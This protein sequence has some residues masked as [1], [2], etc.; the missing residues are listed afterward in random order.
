MAKRIVR[1]DLEFYQQS[2]EKWWHPDAKIYALHHLNPLCFEYFERHI[3]NWQGLKVLDV[4]CSG[5]FSCEFVAARQAQVYSIDRAQNCIVIAK[6][7][8]ASNDLKLTIK[9]AL[10]NLCLILTIILMLCFA[11]M[12]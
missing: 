12:F 1:N 6:A 3:T 4:G 8:A 9:L 10:L 11:L 2:A 5:G 7:H